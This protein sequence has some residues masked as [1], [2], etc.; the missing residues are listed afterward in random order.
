MLGRRL[1]QTEMCS[2]SFWLDCSTQCRENGILSA[3]LLDRSDEDTDKGF[4]QN[5][6]TD[7]FKVAAV[8][9]KCL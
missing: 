7:I 2:E 5:G 8:P 6:L 9:K 3:G 4:L 1:E